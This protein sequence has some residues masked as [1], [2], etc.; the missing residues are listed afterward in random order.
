[1]EQSDKEVSDGRKR[2]RRKSKKNMVGPL[3]TSS[4]IEQEKKRRRR[5]RTKVDGVEEVEDKDK[6]DSD[7]K[8][9]VSA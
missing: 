8:R 1:M 7:S 2:R 3:M 6:E 4:V 9:G 5:R